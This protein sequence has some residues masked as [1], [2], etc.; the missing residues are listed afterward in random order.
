MKFDRSSNVYAEP[1]LAE[2][3]ANSKQKSNPPPP[4]PATATAMEPNRRCAKSQSVQLQNP[5]ESDL[6]LALFL[7]LSVAP[8]LSLSCDDDDDKYKPIR[9]PIFLSE[10]HPPATPSL[11]DK[12]QIRCPASSDTF[13]CLPPSFLPR[14]LLSCAHS[15]ALN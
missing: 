12:D 14:C 1:Q 3:S 11:G 13:S 8:S 15:I 10:S 2:T 4:L 5:K 7:P 9:R 6:A